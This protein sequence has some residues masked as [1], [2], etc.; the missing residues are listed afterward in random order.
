VLVEHG[1]CSFR[2]GPWTWPVNVRGPQLLVHLLP[3]DIPVGSCAC[4]VPVHQPSP[5]SDPANA[6]AHR[7]TEVRPCPGDGGGMGDK[8]TWD[9]YR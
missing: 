9:A 5:L 4:F 7:S 3:V 1:P 2:T 8:E 6:T